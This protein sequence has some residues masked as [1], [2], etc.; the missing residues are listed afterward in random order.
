LVLDSQ[1]GQVWTVTGRRSQ[2]NQHR[3]VEQARAVA[4]M[5][6]Q[7]AEVGVEVVEETPYEP[8]VD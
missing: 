8:R 7:L 1:A 4:A 3:K 2:S 5:I 6:D